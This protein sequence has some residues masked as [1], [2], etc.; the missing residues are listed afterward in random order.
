MHIK[1]RLAKPNWLKWIP[2][3]VW[4]IAI[5]YLSFSSLEHVNL[6][7]F[8]AADKIAH[9][10]MYAV[11]VYFLSIPLKGKTNAFAIGVVTAIVFSAFTELIQHFWV[12]NRFG[13]PFDFLANV[14]GIFSA[15]FFL[16]K[17]IKT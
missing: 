2:L 7:Q 16:R 11:L 14:L 3:L 15:Y 1:K 4:V 6:P 17:R 12:I 5:C 13:D 8:S 10:G 9:W